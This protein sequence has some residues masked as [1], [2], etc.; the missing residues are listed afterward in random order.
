MI[1]NAKNKLINK[2]L[3]IIIANQIKENG[4]P[5]GSDTNQVSFI[6]KTFVKSLE[7]DSKANIAKQLLD[8]IKQEGQVFSELS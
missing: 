4:Y 7:R 2:K 1:A 8:L 5:F 6:S 3:D